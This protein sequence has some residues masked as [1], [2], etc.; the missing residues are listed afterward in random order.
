MISISKDQV[1][2]MGYKG[3]T[4]P[5]FVHIDEIDTGIKTK[6]HIYLKRTRG[7][8]PM[9]DIKSL[10]NGQAVLTKTDIT[11]YYQYDNVYYGSDNCFY[12]LQAMNLGMFYAPYVPS[13][14]INLPIIKQYLDPN[15]ILPITAIT[16]PPARIVR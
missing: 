12:I 15:T 8:E 5:W 4:G 9:S 6:P 13:I 2:L 10:K 1:V 7:G 3:E 16:Y 11:I 14:R